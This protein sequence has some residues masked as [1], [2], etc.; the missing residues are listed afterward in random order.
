MKNKRYYILSFI[1]P[2]VLMILLYLSVGVIGGNKNILT[3]DLADQYIAFFN[4]L[5]NILSGTINPFFSFSKTL[6][7]NLFGIITYYLISPFNI[8][9]LLFNKTDLPI[10]ILII[11]ILKISFAGLTS[12]IYFNKTFKNNNITSLTFSIIYSIMAYNI[13]YSQNIMWLDGVIL[14]PIVFL[15]IDK[16]IEK[17]PTLFYLSLTIS[18]ICNYY[19]GY[20]TCIASMIYFIYKD[21]L[22]EEKIIINNIINFT[23][24]LLLAVLTSS[25]VLIPSI[26]SL[27][28]GKA[29][30]ILKEFI[31]NQKFAIFDIITRFYIG[32]F[33]NSD[34]EGGCPNIYISLISII[35][36]VYY[37]FNKK[38]SKQEKK[39]TLILL[40]VF[41]ISFIFY[42]ID[43]IW[44]TFKHPYGFPF[45]Y[46]FIFDFIILIIAY[47]SLLKLDTIP[48]EF[49]KKFTI[50][51]FILTII[52]DKLLYTS[53]M[54]YKAL[55]TF[56]LIVIYLLYLSKNKSIKKTILLLIIIEMFINDFIILCNIKYQ[57]KKEYKDFIT[58][59]GNI[60]E[61]LNQK[62]NFYRLEKDYSYSTNDELLLNYNGI[63]HFSSV[64]EA[65]NNELL[66]KKLGIFNRFYITN[67]N[68]STLVTNSLFD[69]KYL[70]TKEQKNYYINTNTFKEINIYENNY[71]LPLGFT[72]DKQLHQ[73][74]LKDY[75]PFE[76]QNNILKSMNENIE[77][78]FIK[79]YAKVTL[80]N[81]KQEDTKKLTYKKI[82]NNIPA[83][84]TFEINQS[85]NGILYAY[86]SSKTN[87]KVNIKLNGEEMIDISD[88]NNYNYNILELGTFENN[89]PIKLEV[90]L[91]DDTIKLEN[92]MFYTLDLNKFSSAINILKQEDELKIIENNKNYLKTKIN[93]KSNN[94]ILYTSIPYDENIEVKVDGKEIKPI[95]TLDTLLAL[96]LEKGEHEIIITYKAKGLKPGIILSITGLMLFVFKRKK[97]S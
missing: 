2:C 45:R 82:N 55:A 53:T 77:D 78:V 48:K 19:I 64:Y 32:T 60:I 69:I 90:E 58:N 16:L 20:M 67:Y 86:L 65:N 72:V 70:L 18:I 9:V 5:K 52:V 57:D 23:K 6:G 63:S 85:N 43:V 80:K 38:I 7:G 83:S 1:I 93:I 26:F 92:Y 24:Y 22:K 84:I 4:A 25:I 33:K 50:Y 47:K 94:K 44:H 61:S 79:E 39:A 34:L 12:Y 29:N 11:N 41:A 37:F 42:P 71:N 21:Y 46:S 59:T 30:G 87:K 75:E 68:G 8:I 14:L 62:E 74:K 40:S 88:Q 35:L 54:Y 66:G 73:L 97:D 17:K 3:V 91:L 56:V 89:M 27:L 13:V 15:G 49:I 81:L 10:A 36:L 28:S 51:A 96:D 95:K 31:P 76:N